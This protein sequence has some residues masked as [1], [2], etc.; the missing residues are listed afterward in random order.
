MT[1]S[2]VIRIYLHETVCANLIDDNV[3]V[4][5]YSLIIAVDT[6]AITGYRILLVVKDINCKSYYLLFDSRNETKSVSQAPS[7]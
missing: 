4:T 5:I 1:N 2:K 7:W 3:S 6:L